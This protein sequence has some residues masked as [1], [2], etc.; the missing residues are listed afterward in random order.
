MNHRVSI[1]IVLGLGA[2]L[3][4]GGA[5]LWW[6]GGNLS[7]VVIWL[8]A[9]NQWLADTLIERMGYA[10]VFGL[11]FIESS[12]IPF[13]SEIIIPPAAD[14]ARRLPDWDLITVILLGCAGSLGG[15]LF[16][17]TLAFYLGR[18]LLLG[19]IGRYGKFVRLSPAG[20]EK[21]EAFFLRHG[22][23]STFTGR[24]LVGIRQLISLPAGLARMNLIVFCLLTSLGAG[25]WV[26]ML[27]LAGYWFGGN[28]EAL[29]KAM[30]AYSSWIA[31]GVAILIAGY[32]IFRWWAAKR[33]DSKKTERAPL[34]GAG[35]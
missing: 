4:A 23:I 33:T 9:A 2:V 20:F 28:A 34:E 30:G 22:A 12:F 7:E 1:L 27:A 5:G 11:M 18:P 24:L 3:A 25:I 29:A 16:N 6:W 10:G 31:L 15:A 32:V 13:P 17:Y 14:L 21:A 35:S 26:V 8:A 19:L